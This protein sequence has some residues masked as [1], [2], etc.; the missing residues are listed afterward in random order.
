MAKNKEPKS[1]QEKLTLW[2]TKR[3]SVA[4]E[5]SRRECLREEG[6]PNIVKYC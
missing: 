1:D 2:E 6:M 4:V 5:K 3:A